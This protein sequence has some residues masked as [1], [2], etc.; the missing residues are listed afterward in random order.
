MAG[1]QPEI[2]TIPE[3]KIDEEV[4]SKAKEAIE[5]E[6]QVIV[7]VTM[8]TSFTWW[9]LRIWPS[10]FL[11][12]R[13]IGPESKLL[14]AENIPF[15]PQWL[16]VFGNTHRFTLIFEGLP[17]DCE[18]FDLIERIPQEGGFEYFGIRRNRSDVYHIE[19]E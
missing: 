13:G 9:Q 4:I 10:T 18:V 14:N 17:E 5:V 1:Y 3:V 15:Y 19:L 2:I 11:V 8:R 12:P 6:R 16:H 7:H